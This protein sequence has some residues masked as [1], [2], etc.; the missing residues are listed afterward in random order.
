MGATMAGLLKVRTASVSPR[1]EGLS[2]DKDSM[3]TPPVPGLDPR[4]W[5]DGIEEETVWLRRLLIAVTAFLVS[6]WL[7]VATAAWTR[8]LLV[9]HERTY[10][11]VEGNGMEGRVSLEPR[12]EDTTARRLR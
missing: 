12:I 9:T 3:K 10:E 1:Q 2:A 7:G 6:V 11:S 8:A 4:D 5:N